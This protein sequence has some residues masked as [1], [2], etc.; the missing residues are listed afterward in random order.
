MVVGV[1][2]EVETGEGVA[3]GGDVAVGVDVGSESARMPATKKRLRNQTT[4]G[5]DRVVDEGD[6]AQAAG[7]EGAGAAADP[8]VA[9]LGQLEVAS[10]TPSRLRRS[11]RLPSAVGRVTS[12]VQ[13]AP[14]LTL[15]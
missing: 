1:T 12:K 15:P 9:V 10:S 11:W 7:L 8:E 2:V 6:Q 13:A 3:V 5:S 14:E 4:P